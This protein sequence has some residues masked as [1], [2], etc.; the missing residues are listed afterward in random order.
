MTQYM[1]GSL[2]SNA[3]GKFMTANRISTHMM[4][5]G[6]MVTDAE[7]ALKF[8]RDT[9]GFQEFWR[10]GPRDGQLSWINLRTPGTRGDYIELMI[11]EPNPDR[12]RLGSMQH[13]CLE[14]PDIQAAH[15]KVGE[16][17]TEPKIGRNGRWQVNL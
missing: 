10:G 15:K 2:H 16:A 17:G 1:P 9:L 14:T 7:R 13:I 8:Y 3:R 5:A 11:S 12:G 4:H 6:V